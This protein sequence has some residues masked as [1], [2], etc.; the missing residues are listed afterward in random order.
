ML[1]LDQ[2]F[3]DTR[4]IK[5]LVVPIGENS[6]FDSHFQVVSTLRDMQLYEL[7]RPSTWKAQVSPFK[8]F[9]WNTGNLLFDYLRYD[10]VPNGPGD[11]DNFQAS[12]R[13]L[14]IMGLINYPELGPN[15]NATIQEELDFFTR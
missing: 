13:V 3:D 4:A 15:P 11:L 6:L 9:N 5:V 2:T 1:S 10:R 14:M 7:N 8:N 12:R